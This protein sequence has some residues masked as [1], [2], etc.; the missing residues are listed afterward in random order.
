M[1]DLIINADG[2]GL[3]PL[4]NEAIFRAAQHGVVT[5]TS[6]LAN[7]VD[8]DS[9]QRLI[10]QTPSISIGIEFNLTCGKSLT[11]AT[12]L[13]NENGEFFPVAAWPERV[14]DVDAAEVIAELQA[15][16]DRA[17]ELLGRMPTHINAHFHVPFLLPM[18]LNYLLQLA[19]QYKIPMRELPF[20]ENHVLVWKKLY[21]YLH[22]WSESFVLTQL[23]KSRLVFEQY[24]P[25]MPARLASRF[26][27]PLIT[28]GDL[29]NILTVL[30]NDRPTELMTHISL[31]NNPQILYPKEAYQSLASLIHPTTREVIESLPIHLV[32]YADIGLSH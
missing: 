26:Y 13:I 18:A 25:W 21:R 17:T 9:V 2:F 19:S 20:G 4:T 22:E 16:W 23:E 31:P 7:L 12:S 14:E 5:S 11:T 28:L 10:Q 27:P 15:Q 8:S 32:N 6:L 3:H 30:P 1:P 29:L 24:I